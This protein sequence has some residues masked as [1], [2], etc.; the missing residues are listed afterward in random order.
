MKRTLLAILILALP[1]MVE[2][3]AAYPGYPD[4]LICA[5]EDGMGAVNGSRIIELYKV[6]SP[7]TVG[8][9]VI[10][11][12]SGNLTFDASGNY[13]AGEEG[14][15]CDPSIGGV[16]NLFNYSTATPDMTSGF[17]PPY[18]RFFGY[19]TTSQLILTPPGDYPIA[20][21]FYGFIMFFISGYAVIAFFR[22]RT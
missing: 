3:Q 18:A 6:P 12:D 17:V 15:S 21:L 22:R 4:A 5:N 20:D 2:A 8:G 7:D 13:Q 10:Q 9:A 14:T 16:S 19:S 1:G 11:Y